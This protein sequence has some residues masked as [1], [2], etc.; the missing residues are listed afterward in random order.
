M[1]A[2]IL[3]LT[4]KKWINQVI[5]TGFFGLAQKAPHWLSRELPRAAG[6]WYNR[7]F[8][9]ASSL[10]LNPEDPGDR[11]YRFEAPELRE[12]NHHLAV[13]AY[14]FCSNTRGLCTGRCW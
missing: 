9:S 6:R 12:L 8:Q 10:G 4:P 13:Q 3:G 11:L 5:I 14:R 1:A 2:R 7:F